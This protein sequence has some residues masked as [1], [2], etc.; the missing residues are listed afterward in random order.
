M[1]WLSPQVSQVRLAYSAAQC[2]G[3]APPP[4]L[5]IFN[6]FQ[7]STQRRR[8]RSLIYTKPKFRAGVSINLFPAFLFRA[9][10]SKASVD[11]N[12]QSRMRKRTLAYYSSG[13]QVPN[14]VATV[15]HVVSLSTLPRRQWLQKVVG[16]VRS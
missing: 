1:R 13:A 14:V 10:S 2:K 11:P 9:I 3:S 8:G 16:N 12:T 4:A 7:S 15:K 6:S 5:N